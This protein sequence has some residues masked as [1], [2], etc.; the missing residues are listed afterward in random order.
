[1]VSAI[2]NFSF[3]AS[4]ALLPS[5][6]LYSVLLVRSVIAF[7]RHL[8]LK[9]KIITPVFLSSTSSG[10]PPTLVTTAG[11]PCAIPSII[12]LGRPSLREGATL[13][14]SAPISEGASSRDP[15]KWARSATRESAAKVWI[16]GSRIS[17]MK[18]P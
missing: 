7:A 14:S 13:I 4:L 15:V 11:T 8:Q 5:S 2:L 18:S 16:S 17:P 9:S 3:M 10:K 6:F 12:D 1:M